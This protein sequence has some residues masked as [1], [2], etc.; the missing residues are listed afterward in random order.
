MT[1]ISKVLVQSNFKA[2][3]YLCL[4]RRRCSRCRLQHLHVTSWIRALFSKALSM[5]KHRP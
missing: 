2:A 5:G 3:W 1:F 4:R